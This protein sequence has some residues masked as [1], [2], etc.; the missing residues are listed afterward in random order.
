MSVA[1]A[2]VASRLSRPHTPSG[3]I[4]HVLVDEH[5]LDY[6]LVLGDL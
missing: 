6:N 2:G 4:L 3:V 1:A 5:E